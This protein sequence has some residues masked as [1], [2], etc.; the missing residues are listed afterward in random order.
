MLFALWVVSPI[1]VPAGADH[2]RHQQK[3]HNA[4]DNERDLDWKSQKNECHHNH[5]TYLRLSAQRARHDAPP[6]IAS[7]HHCGHGRGRACAV[8]DA[9]RPPP[10][11]F[12]GT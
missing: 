9:R 3:Q 11:R 7:F 4:R 5:E 12:P 2:P 8:P 1:S 10:L 6:Q